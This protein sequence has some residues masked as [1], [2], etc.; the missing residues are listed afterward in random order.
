MDE[1]LSLYDHHL[2][3]GDHL[4]VAHTWDEFRRL[5][6]Q[7]Q[8]H[9]IYYY[10]HGKGDRHRSRL[11]FATDQGQP[12]EKPIADLA[13]CLRE[14]EPRPLLAYL[15]CCSGDAG[16][17]LGAGWQL[18]AFIP[19]VITNRAPARID[20]AQAQAL[21]LWQGILLDG[22]PPHAALARVR[23]ELPEMDLSFGDPRWLTPVIHCHYAGWQSTPPQR[24]NP[25][26]HDPYWHLKLDRVSQFALLAGRGAIEDAGLTADQLSSAA[27]VIGT[28][29]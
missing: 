21:A 29:C 6:A 10:G 12:V 3:L 28:G 9:I 22:Q 23:A 25:L 14:A 7:F 19:A 15:N 20:A 13:Q 17:F 24:V 2:S 5:L 16:G 26:E 1:R 4:R 18:G 8:P 27:A 11:L